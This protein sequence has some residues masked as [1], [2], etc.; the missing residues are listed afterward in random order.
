MKRFVKDAHIH[1]MICVLT[2]IRGIERIN[3]FAEGGTLEQ[4][5]GRC[6]VQRDKKK[7]ANKRACRD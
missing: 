2:R 4:W 7:E 5:R 1:K 6:Q 3:H